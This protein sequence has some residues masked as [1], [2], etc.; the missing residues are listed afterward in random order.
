MTNKEIYELVK[1]NK[2]MLAIVPKT[3][4][5]TKTQ[6]PTNFGELHP[7]A[8]LTDPQ[9]FHIRHMYENNGVRVCDLAIEFNISYR[10]TQNILSYKTRNN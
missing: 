5:L 9:V 1:K 2:R 4:L 6:E 3:V 10:H 7:Y 8:K